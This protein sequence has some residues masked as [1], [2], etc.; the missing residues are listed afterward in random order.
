M[1][2]ASAAEILAVEPVM[3]KQEGRD[4]GTGL[5]GQHF[6]R[7]KVNGNKLTDNASQ[8]ETIGYSFL[9]TPTAHQVDQILGLYRLAEW[10]TDGVD[11]PGAIEPL[12]AGSHCFAI[13]S[14]EDDIIGMGRA[15]SDGV[16]DAYIQDITVKPSY[17]RRGIASRLVT[18]LIKHLR[19]DG[20]TWIG[21]IAER[22]TE[23]FYRQLDFETMPDSTPML[24]KTP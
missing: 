1:R 7:G 24:L 17:R 22:G 14:I 5:T 3:S 19:A 23:K 2:N 8:S 21:L 11:D 4:N 15:I 6:L 18:E 20:L 12:I 13:A 10:W 9:D 16:G